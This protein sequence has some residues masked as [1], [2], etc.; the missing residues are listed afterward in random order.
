MKLLN[1]IPT[2]IAEKTTNDGKKTFFSRYESINN[3]KR[4]LRIWRGEGFI[5]GFIEDDLAP[6]RQFLDEINLRGKSSHVKTADGCK[7]SLL[8]CEKGRGKRQSYQINCRSMF[9]SGGRSGSA[10]FIAAPFLCAGDG[11]SRTSFGET[12]PFRQSPIAPPLSL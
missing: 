2:K 3:W 6:Y 9:C 8:R 4:R 1:E 11:G 12:S 10:D 5:E 7:S